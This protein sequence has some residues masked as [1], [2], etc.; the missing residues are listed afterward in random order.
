MQQ[1]PGK[2]TKLAKSKHIYT[3]IVSPTVQLIEVH[4]RLMA[5]EK[6]LKLHIYTNTYLLT[7]L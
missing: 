6:Q 2:N 4:F 7:D 1:V 5:L 3:H